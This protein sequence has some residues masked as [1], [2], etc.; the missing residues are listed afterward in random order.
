HS[1]TAAQMLEGKWVKL[2]KNYSVLEQVLAVPLSFTNPKWIFHVTGLMSRK[3]TNKGATT[4]KGQNVVA[5][6]S[7]V[8]GRNEN[9][10]YYVANSGT[11]YPG[12]AGSDLAGA[13]T[14]DS[15]NK[16]VTLT[17]PAGAV[18]FSHLSGG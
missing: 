16:P 17:A 2:P 15:W 3:F 12:A 13:E 8:V 6:D 9:V 18:D 1:S 11:A 5:V 14:Y 4:Y 7:K 10:T